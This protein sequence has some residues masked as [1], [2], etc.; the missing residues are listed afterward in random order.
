ME[1]QQAISATSQTQITSSA[2]LHQE[3]FLQLSTEKETLAG[4]I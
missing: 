2:T 3:K 4:Y 1:E